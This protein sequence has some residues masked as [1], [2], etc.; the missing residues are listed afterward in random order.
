MLWREDARAGRLFSTAN[1]T[2][3]GYWAYLV[4]KSSLRQRSLK[5]AITSRW[6]R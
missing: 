2:M 6:S 3:L 5:I 4:M 1:D